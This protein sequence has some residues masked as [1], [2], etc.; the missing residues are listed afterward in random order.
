[1][2]EEITLLRD[3]AVVTIVAAAVTILFHRFRQPVVVGYIIAG[4]IIGPHA[5]PFPLVKNFHNIETLSQLGIVFL[6]FSLGLEFN[7]RKFRRIAPTAGPAATLCALLLIWLGYGVGKLLG[8]GTMDSLFLGA[9]VSISSST[10]VVKTFQSLGKMS[11]RYAQTALG[12][13]LVEDVIVVVILAT[14]SSVAMTG[15]FAVGEVLDTLMRMGIFIVAVILFGML[16][17]PRLVTYV[18]K[19]ND[20]EVLVVTALGLCFGLA[21]M[22]VNLGY[23]AALGAFIMGAIVSESPA[24]TRLE[25][26][27]KPIRDLFVAVFFVSVGMLLDPKIVWANIGPALGVAAL[28]IVGRSLIASF[29][30]FTMGVEGCTALR[31]GLGL[32]PLGEFSF[33]IAQVGV[34][35]GRV[36]DFLFPVAVAASAITALTAPYLVRSSDRLVDFLGRIAPKPLVTFL[37]F[38]SDWVGSL[39]APGKGSTLWRFI[40]RPIVHIMVE[41]A[42]VTAMFIAASFAVGWVKEMFPERML[43]D[44]EVEMLMWLIVALVSLPPFLAMWR[45]FE[46]I[47]LVI[48][49]TAIPNI[50]S[51]RLPPETLQRLLKNAILLLGAVVLGLWIIAL[52]M[53]FLPPLPLFIMLGLA[54]FVVLRMQW[55]SIVLLHSR[56]ESAVREVLTELPEAKPSQE[57]EIRNLIR[58]KYPWDFELVEFTL[59]Q[60]SAAAGHTIRELSLRKRTG[61]TIVGIQR[62]G[63]HIVNPS[64]GVPLF[65]KDVLVLMGEKQQIEEAKKILQQKTARKAEPSHGPTN[66]EIDSFAVPADS[67]LAGKTI[68]ESRLRQLTGATIIGIQRGEQRLQNPSGDTRIECGDVIL[69]LGNRQQLDLA[70]ILVEKS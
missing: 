47:A 9:I 13:I 52:S 19:F 59:P 50:S 42:V 65:P 44:H 11:E 53:S 10:V 18:G 25:P 2:H 32:T 29:A 40:R 39:G 35:S 70:K 68:T 48:A 17:V 33:L 5:P 64:P 15:S 28:A 24:Y 7:L 12:F 51:K 60:D 45:N 23:S 67:S 22:A 31:V 6:L 63:F 58:E 55:H 46:V 56:L 69:L 36:S 38:Y 30:N 26:L 61:A 49:E 8:W 1:M 21:L 41:A 34:A 62:E 20:D 57:A 4:L 14:L 43:F 27:V 3:L 66:I 37:G 16:L 54:V